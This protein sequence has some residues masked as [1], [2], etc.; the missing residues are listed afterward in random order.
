MR[1]MKDSGIE[2]IG[3]IPRHWEIRKVKNY[4]TMQTGFTPNTKNESYYDD[5]NGYDWVNISDIQDGKII[6]DT[7]KKISQHYIDTYAPKIIPKGSLLYSFKL[8]VGQTAY[9]GKPIYSN[10]AIASFLPAENVNLHYLRYSSMFIIENAQTNI[11]NAKILNQD[12]INNAFI[13][14]PPLNEQ[15]TIADFLDK[16]CAEIDSVIEQTK[17][18]IEEYKKLK[19]SVITEAVTK[20]IRG[21]RPMKDSG[22]EWIGEI[23]LAHPL[24]KLKYVCKILDQY[25]SPITSDQRSQEGEILYDYYGASGVIDKIDGYTIDDHVMLIGEDGANLRMRNLPLM[26]EV[27]GKAWINNHA[28]ILKPN[29]DTDFYYLFFALEALDINP[30]ITGSAQPKLSQDNLRNIF[31]PMP[32]FEEQR[33][34]SNYLIEKCA[35]IDTLIEKKTALIEEMEALKKATIFE[36]VTGKKKVLS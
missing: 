31:I 10:E 29:D 23:A 19:Q 5:I 6:T 32:S 36:Y 8:S 25:R 34:I 7:K 1:E 17:A 22:I 27:N 14:F 2:W 28:H 3:E 30:Y 16:Q 24:K 35:E 9:A 12:L 21:E 4:Y 33:E 18:T 20:G 15:E 13:V 11:Y 26:Y